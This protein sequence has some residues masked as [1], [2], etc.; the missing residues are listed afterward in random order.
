MFTVVSIHDDKY[1]PLADLTNKNKI[2]YCE[3]H[4]YNF[5][6]KNDWSSMKIHAGNPP[7]PQGYIP[8][9]YTKIFAIKEAI[10]KYPKTS[11]VFFSE[12]D[13]IITNKNI[14][15]EDIIE[16]Y[17]DKHFIISADKNGINSGNFLVRNSEIG[18]GFLNNILSSMPLYK[19][20]YLFEN[21]YIQD[22]LI[23]SRLTEQGVMNGGSLWA[24]VSAVVPQRVINSYD[25]KN[26][27]KLNEPYNDILGNDGQWHKDDFVLHWPNT[28]LEERIQKVKNHL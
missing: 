23:G 11:W 18:M 20:Y 19:H 9:G 4:G 16:K 22:C 7:V 1:K 17:I 24:N 5:F 13:A 15:L 12:C 28:P 25:Y 3:K 6:V 10:R 2:E 27:S 8:I 14:K 26:H 21:Q